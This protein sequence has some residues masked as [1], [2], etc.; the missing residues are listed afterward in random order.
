MDWREFRA[1]LVFLRHYLELF[2]MFDEIDTSDDR[3][4][5]PELRGGIPRLLDVW[6]I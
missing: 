3:R 2:A 4:V 5:R 6:A 1:L